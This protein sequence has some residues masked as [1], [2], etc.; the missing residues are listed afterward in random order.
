MGNTQTYTKF[1]P[2]IL[3]SRKEEHTKCLHDEHA[4][5]KQ[6]HDLYINNFQDVLTQHV[7]KNSQ[8]IYGHAASGGS[9]YVVLKSTSKCELIEE[10]MLKMSDFEYKTLKFSYEASFLS[11]QS[12]E[13]LR[14]MDIGSSQEYVD[15]SECKIYAHW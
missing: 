4:S 14:D 2:K 9:R 6:K 13:Y 1:D 5:E 3:D 7:D 8:N 11:A 15:L 12:D 10:A